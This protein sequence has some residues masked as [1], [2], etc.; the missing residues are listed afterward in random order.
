ME[1]DPLV[2]IAYVAAFAMSNYSSTFGRIAKPFNPMLVREYV[3]E[4]TLPRLMKLRA[5]LSS[6]WI[7]SS[8]T[9]IFPNKSAIIL[10]SRRVGQ[11]LPLGGTTGRY[12]RLI[13]DICVLLMRVISKV[14]AQSKFVG[15]SYEIR[16]TGVAH[17]ELLLEEEW[18]PDYP[19]DKHPR[20]VGKVVEH[21]S[22]KKVI[23]SISGFMLGSPT[24][25]HYGE[26]IVRCA[27]S[28][29]LWSPGTDELRRSQTT[30]PGI[31]VD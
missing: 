8:N 13:H 2:R 9:G 1:R 26:M 17:A 7:S 11:S 10:Q 20:N 22:W 21:Y 5:K 15:K 14:D 12:A 23:T 6:T 19:Q 31:N 3:P 27:I 25:D 4:R 29:V 18:A 24:I 28:F 16:P 30:V